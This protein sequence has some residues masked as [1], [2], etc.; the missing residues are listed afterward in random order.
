LPSPPIEHVRHE[1]NKRII[2]FRVGAHLDR[3]LL[4]IVPEIA[5]DFGDTLCGLM[6]VRLAYQLFDQTHE[7]HRLFRYCPRVSKIA[8]SCAT[9]AFSSIIATTKF[10]ATSFSSFCAS[11]R[12]FRSSQNGMAKIG[13]A[14]PPARFDLFEQ[15][16]NR[17][18]APP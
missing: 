5:R 16:D 18:A 8:D 6:L 9:I 13:A 10:S 14:R 17:H 1:R 4:N 7:H 12:S 3:K 11:C 2:R 15:F